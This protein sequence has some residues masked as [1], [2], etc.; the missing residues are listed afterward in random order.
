MM[1]ETRTR[2]V[3]AQVEDE[4]RRLR[5]SNDIP[6]ESAGPSPWSRRATPT[7]PRLTPGIARAAPT[8]TRPR[9]SI[10]SSPGFA[11]GCSRCAAPGMISCARPRCSFSS[12]IASTKPSRRR[13]E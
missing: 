13:P 2:G 10:A 3:L 11:R 6:P 9:R 5:T 12:W 8:R 1:P 4:I 7:P